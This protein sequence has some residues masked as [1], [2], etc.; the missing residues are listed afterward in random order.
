MAE[1]FDSIYYCTNC[2]FAECS[3]VDFGGAKNFG[4]NAKESAPNVVGFNGLLQPIADG[5]KLLTKEIIMPRVA[6]LFVFK[7]A[8]FTSFTLALS[9][10]SVIPLL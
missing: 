4:G 5:V 9:V 3:V 1:Y 8:P 2:S 10:W 7:L 6:D